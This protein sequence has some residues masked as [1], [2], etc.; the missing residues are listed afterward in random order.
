MKILF[1]HTTSY[2]FGKEEPLIDKQIQLLK[3]RF[4][5][6]YIISSDTGI[7]IA[8]TTPSNVITKNVVLEFDY[9][10]KLKSLLFLFK[11]NVLKEI[12]LIKTEYKQPFTISRLKVL[13]NSYTIG[14]KYNDFLSEI[15][16]NES[17]EHE[18]LF[19]HSYWCTDAVLGFTMLKDKFPNI[20]TYTRMHAYDLYFERHTPE[21]LPFRKLI[22]KKIDKIFFISDQG[23]EYFL[24]KTNLDGTSGK[25]IVN[26]LGVFNNTDLIENT[27][28]EN[29]TI[30]SCS[31]I[32]P[33]KRIHL[34][35]EILTLIDNFPIKWIHFGSGELENEI[36]TLA[37]IKLGNHQNVDFEFKGFV[38][39]DEIHEFYKTNPIDLFIN[40]SEYEGIPISLM[41]A[42]S[43]SIPCVGTD[44]G[45][46]SEIINEKNG[47]LIDVDFKPSEV[48]KIIENYYNLHPTSKGQIRQNAFE[49]WKTKYDGNKNTLR[50]IQEI[51]TEPI[52]CS[53]CL[54]TDSD[55][56]EIEFDHEGVCSICHIYD[57]LQS[58]TVFK[59]EIGQ[60]KLDELLTQVK[61]AG[62][63]NKFNC[64]VG[65][66]GGVDSSYLAY[67][68]KEWGLKP[69]IVHIDNGWN[70]ELA[71]KNIENI[72]TKLDLNLDTHVIKWEDMRDIQLAFF[73][74]SV[75]DIDLPFDNA[76]MALLY[77]IAKKHNIKYILSGHNT[78][79]EGWMPPSFTHYKLDTINIKAI[80]KRYG[81]KRIKNFKLLNPIQKW[82]YSKIR[83]IKMVAPL[84]LVKYNKSEVKDFLMYKLDWKDYGG[85]HYENIFTKFYQGH[86]LPEKFKIDKRKA[87][88]STLICSGQI[89]KKDALLELKKS[90][91]NEDE[92][93]DDKAYFIKK[94]KISEDE[95]ETIMA[96]P[97]KS[98]T[99]FPSYIN[100][101]N[102]LRKIKRILLFRSNN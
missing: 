90:P 49:T 45:G 55:Y 4:D 87:H 91:Y 36:S 46:V 13:L 50:L 20:K 41:E 17:L 70:S 73:K 32:I 7:D 83:G 48:K 18:E 22:G 56:P 26:R 66:S 89:D 88:L 80:H 27:K 47:Y 2:P 84:D 35:I 98:H 71:I 61:Q 72:L 31:S 64:I 93:K 74:A 62:K 86:L 33:L 6:I 78:V 1:L 101:I 25:Y 3:K 40:V 10:Q 76:F 14:R 38:D 28:N 23:K 57:K 81:T 9:K 42:M 99:D 102:K 19:F 21:Y 39:N 44:V 5:Y 67:L 95:F 52:M 29:F 37:K 94:M 8:Y 96:L 30:V 11:K 54:Y 77:K 12:K 58:R 68:S 63:K 69:L 15:I 92:L 97:V 85:K 79:T 75:I 24:N 43:N 16:Q 65:V 100:I 82:Y 51:E 59:N 53:K 60:Q 34:I